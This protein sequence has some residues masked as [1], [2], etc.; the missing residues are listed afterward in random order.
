M[1]VK[2]FAIWDDAAKAY[3][4]PFFMQNDAVAVRSFGNAV[5]KAES[6]LYQNPE[7]YSLFTFGDFDDNSGVFRVAEATLLVTGKELSRRAM[8][9]PEL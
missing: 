1:K 8:V 4:V 5:N 2:V 3:M 9:G 6:Q 7:S